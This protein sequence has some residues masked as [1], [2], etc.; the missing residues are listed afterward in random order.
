MRP[1]PNNIAANIPA[2]LSKL[3]KIVN[4][5]DI[6]HLICWSSDGRSFTIHNQAQFWYSLLPA[7]YKHNNMS[8][9]IRQLNMYGFHKLS[10]EGGGIDCDRDD[11]RFYHPYFQQDQ[12]NLLKLIKRKM[13]STKTTGTTV[14]TTKVSNVDQMAKVLV[15]VKT[16]RGRQES[17]DNQL[18]NMKHENAA[19]W[20]ELALLRQKH[21]KQ[22]RIVNKLIH[23]LVTIVQPSRSGLSGLGVKRRYPLMIDENRYSKISKVD[24]SSDGPTIHELDPESGLTDHLLLN[25]V[26]EGE[27]TETSMAQVDS[28]KSTTTT[29]TLVDAADAADALLNIPIDDVAQSPAEIIFSGQELDG[30]DLPSTS[31]NLIDAEA[32]ASTSKAEFATKTPSMQQISDKDILSAATEYID[33]NTFINANEDSTLADAPKALDKPIINPSMRDAVISNLVS[34]TEPPAGSKRK[35]LNAAEKLES[36]NKSNMTV[37]TRS[38]VPDLTPKLKL[39]LNSSNDLDNHLETTQGELDTIK[40]MLFDGYSLDTN[41]LLGTNRFDGIPFQ[42]FNPDEDLLF[43]GVPLT[44]PEMKNSNNED[45]MMSGSEIITYN[46]PFMLDFENLFEESPDDALEALSDDP[47]ELTNTSDAPSQINT[48]V[49]VKK[50]P[51]SFPS[52]AKKHQ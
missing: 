4:D 49:I 19:L 43:D 40:E 30:T 10:S 45:P 47:T 21:L 1:K 42:L 51:L 9:F 36:K 25:E 17:V 29:N 31:N 20:R 34:G 18:A 50:E 46:P 52:T 13:A 16:L 26:P 3:W 24:S 7:Y 48:P 23:F 38:S 11:L 8:S 12:P 14:E 6:D 33:L 28:P 15:D 5:P 39:N 37:A 22:Q 27:I 35:V 2:F 41:A 44:S 32:N